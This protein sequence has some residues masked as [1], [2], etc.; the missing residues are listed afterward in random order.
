MGFGVLQ[1]KHGVD[2]YK[3]FGNPVSIFDGSA[4]NKIP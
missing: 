2:R 1:G 4:N 3:S